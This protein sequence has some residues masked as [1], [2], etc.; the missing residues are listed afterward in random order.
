MIWFLIIHVRTKKGPTINK[1]GCGTN[2]RE[3]F[4]LMLFGWGIYLF[5][6]GWVLRDGNG[7]L[8]NLLLDLGS[9]H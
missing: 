9:Y 4:S 6:V 3:Q 1:I 8:L 2:Y 7:Y 5:Q